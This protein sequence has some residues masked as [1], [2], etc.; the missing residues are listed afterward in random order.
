MNNIRDIIAVDG[1]DCVTTGPRDLSASLGLLHD[2]ENP[3]V[4]MLLTQ[5]EK[6]VLDSDPANRRV[7]LA[8]MATAHDSATSLKQRGYQMVLG[9]SDI[10]LF[11]KAA[12]ETIKAFK[13]GA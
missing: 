4:T 3:Q 6:A 8:V 13:T 1:V 5:L 10:S 7:F 11:S 9:G 2:P 12:I